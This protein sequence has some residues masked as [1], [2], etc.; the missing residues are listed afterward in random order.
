MVRQYTRNAY[1]PMLLTTNASNVE[2]EIF[3]D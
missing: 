1:Y 2:E 3:A